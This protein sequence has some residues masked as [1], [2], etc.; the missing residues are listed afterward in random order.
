MAKIFYQSILPV[1]SCDIHIIYIIVILQIYKNLASPFAVSYTAI[2]YF[3]DDICTHAINERNLKNFSINDKEKHFKIQFNRSVT[4]KIKKKM[5]PK[6][7][8]NTCSKIRHL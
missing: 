5:I 4:V 7:K 2:I 3:N 8:H 1:H 6:R